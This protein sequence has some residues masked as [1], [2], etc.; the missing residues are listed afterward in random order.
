M[1]KRDSR[2][3]IRC[4]LEKPHKDYSG[5]SSSFRNSQEFAARS[6]LAFLSEQKNTL[7]CCAR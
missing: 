1:W 3:E 2:S 5:E 6:T 4:H 7:E